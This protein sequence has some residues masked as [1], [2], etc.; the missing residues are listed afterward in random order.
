MRQENTNRRK[1]MEGDDKRYEK[2]IKEDTLIQL[3]YRKTRVG[4]GSVCI[5]KWTF[6]VKS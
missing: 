6:L 2:C 3:R 1:K 4:T 5:M